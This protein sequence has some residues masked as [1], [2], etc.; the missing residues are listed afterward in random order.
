MHSTFNT[1]T[2]DIAHQ[3]AQTSQRFSF[4]IVPHQ[5]G[6]G[7]YALRLLDDGLEVGGGQFCAQGK[8]VQFGDDQSAY[9]EALAT[10]CAWLASRQ[11]D[12]FPDLSH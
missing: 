5:S 2:F 4:E 7:G 11:T 6:T 1:R 12:V 8:A 10:G 9:D 3:A